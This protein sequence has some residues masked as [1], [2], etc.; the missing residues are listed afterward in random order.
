MGSWRVP[1]LFQMIQTRGYVPTEEMYRVF[2]MGVG[3]IAIVAPENVRSIQDAIGEETF[4]IG[5]LIEGEKKV[6]LQL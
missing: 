4:V 2:N 3:M 6:D 5:E 1:P